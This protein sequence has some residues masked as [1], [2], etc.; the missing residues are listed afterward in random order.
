MLHY[1]RLER[2]A[3]DIHSGLLGALRSYVVYEVL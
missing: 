1:T 2:L 3:R